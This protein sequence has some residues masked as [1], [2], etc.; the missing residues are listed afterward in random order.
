MD[1]ITLAML[2][3]MK[4]SGA[5]G[6]EEK[7]RYTFDGNPTGKEIFEYQGNATFVKVSDT[8]HDL[9]DIKSL[10]FCF[11][12][13]GKAET[14]TEIPLTSTSVMPFGQYD[15]VGLVSSAIAELGKDAPL[16]VSVPVENPMASIGTWVL[17]VPLN[18]FQMFVS[19]VTF[20]TIHP[21]DPKFLPGSKVINL[22]DYVI[23]ND[24]ATLSDAIVAM[25]A[26]G[27]DTASIPSI[28]D[29]WEAVNT[30]RPIKFVIDASAL[31]A[32]I[33]ADAKSVMKG[34]GGEI[35]VIETSFIADY[36]GQ[37]RVTVLFF[38]NTP[39]LSVIVETLVVLSE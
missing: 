4:K 26:G 11:K 22:S 34:E 24:G 30:N 36:N 16:V 2:N 7:K 15:I 29:F 12:M 33:E 6:H 9:A 25:F 28:D 19:D 20:E 35:G 1:M 14:I 21:I 10:S 3:S 38:R 5:I 37:H 17:Y 27:G 39:M 18:G 32:V 23:N 13:D 8:V 31:G